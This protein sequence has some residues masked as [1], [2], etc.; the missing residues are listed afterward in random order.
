MRRSPAHELPFG[1][2]RG[3]PERCLCEP[4]LRC[5]SIFFVVLVRQHQG[6]GNHCQA[7]F[8]LVLM[9]C[10]LEMVLWFVNYTGCGASQEIHLRETMRSVSLAIVS[11]GAL[12]H[13]FPLPPRL[14]S[15][16][17]P[18][19]TSSPAPHSPSSLSPLT[20]L[21]FPQDGRREA[22]QRARA[23]GSKGTGRIMRRTSPQ[24]WGW[25]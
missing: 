1:Y 2:V 22:R 3:F 6:W 5:V 10:A 21:F 13:S 9:L 17:R 15:A 11:G 19:A 23:G 16:S 24:G 14:Y 25:F 7:K 12:L 20:A 8:G 18:F 4:P